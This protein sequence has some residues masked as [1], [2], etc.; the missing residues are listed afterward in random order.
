MRKRETGREGEMRGVRRDTDENPL[1]RA[2]TDM[3]MGE[4]LV[5]V[6]H[7]PP[8]PGCCTSLSWC[9]SRR[10]AAALKPNTP[11]LLHPAE[12]VCL[13]PNS[14]LSVCACNTFKYLLFVHVTH[15]PWDIFFSHFLCILALI[16][17]KT[18]VWWWMTCIKG[19]CLK[20]YR[21]TEKI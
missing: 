7:S 6:H 5:V 16:E 21:K 11:E 4:L 20:I 9:Y 13:T 2:G 1:L 17:M 8:P 10:A 14:A 3:I 19:P 18:K 15:A 12:A